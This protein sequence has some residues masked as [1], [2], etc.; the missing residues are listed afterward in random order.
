MFDATPQPAEA[1][2]FSTDVAA[3]REVVRERQEMLAGVSRRGERVVNLARYLDQT[4]LKV[5]G[6]RLRL[7]AA[8]GVDQI[9]PV[10]YRQNLDMNICKLLREVKN[11]T[12]QPRSARRVSIPKDDGSLRHLGLPTT[13]DKHLQ[14]AVLVLL[15]AIYEPQFY[16]HSYGF[17]PHRS[18]KQ[19]LLVL[20][21]W[22]AT[23]N[24]A[25][26]L[27]VDLSKFFD[28]IPHDQL[29]EVLSEKIG[30]RVILHLMNSWLKAGVMDG[31]ILVPS[32]TVSNS[33]GGFRSALRA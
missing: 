1:T 11:K 28:T 9:T 19:A 5:A 25:W 33:G 3:C 30:D 20:L 26:V 18:A 17:R 24:G 10:W 27:E 13:R 29:L 6:S 4:L 22:L 15:E 2:P 21:D 7:G 12:Y 8:A 23:H 32:E 16:P 31:N 14:G